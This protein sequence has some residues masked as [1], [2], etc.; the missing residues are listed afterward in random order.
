VLAEKD[1]GVLEP[2][3]EYLKA[4]RLRRERLLLLVELAAVPEG[5][6]ERL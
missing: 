5:V 1:V 6:V 4:A 3:E 2:L